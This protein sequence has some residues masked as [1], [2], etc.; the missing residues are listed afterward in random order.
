MQYAVVGHLEGCDDDCLVIEA[1]DKHEAELLFREEME[2]DNEDG[3]EIYV[4]F[5]IRSSAKLHIV[6]ANSGFG[7]NVDET[8]LNSNETL[9]PATE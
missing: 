7:I 2:K 5:I 4:T 6:T 3:G 1:K 9:A 8:Q